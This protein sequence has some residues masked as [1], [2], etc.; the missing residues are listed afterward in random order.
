LK[1]V[2]TSHRNCCCIIRT[3]YKSNILFHLYWYNQSVNDIVSCARSL[4]L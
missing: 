4:I 1:G 2:T 3:K